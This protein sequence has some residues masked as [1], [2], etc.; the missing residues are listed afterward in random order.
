MKVLQKYR[1]KGDR[2]QKRV[3][4]VDCP[5]EWIDT[6]MRA[7]PYKFSDLVRVSKK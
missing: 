5:D 4:K 1:V 7:T 6:D 3:I 2:Y